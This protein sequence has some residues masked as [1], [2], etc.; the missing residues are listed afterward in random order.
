MF[1][2]L[3]SFSGSLAMKCVSMS[4]ELCQARLMLVDINSYEH[5][6]YPLTVS[7]NKCSESCNTIDDPY[8]Q[9]YII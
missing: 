4:N 8:A 1:I 7:V 9:I 3:L 5:L 6:Y 2:R